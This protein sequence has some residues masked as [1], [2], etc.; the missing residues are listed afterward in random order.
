MTNVFFDV[1]NTRQYQ[2]TRISVLNRLSFFPVKFRLKLKGPLYDNPAASKEKNRYI[3]EH[4]QQTYPPQN[5]V[6]TYSSQELTNE[7]P[8]F[9]DLFFVF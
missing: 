6:N 4:E 5:V 9:F 3:G 7:F 2:H 8:C 1:L